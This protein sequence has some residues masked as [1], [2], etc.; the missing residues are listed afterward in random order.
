MITVDSRK[1]PVSLVPAANK[2]VVSTF[3]ET[4]IAVHERKS[5]A[6]PVTLLGQR[7][8]RYLQVTEKIYNELLRHDQER[9]VFRWT[10]D[11][12]FPGDMLTGINQGAS[13]CLYMGHG[14]PTGWSG[15]YGV[16]SHHIAAFKYK[17]AAAIISLCCWTAGRKD[18][19]FSFCES[20]IMQGI[21]AFAIGAVKP[22]LF[23]ENTRWA[24]NFSTAM[25]RGVETA[26]AL[27][28]A[29]CPSQRSADHYRLFG[30][31]TVPLLADEGF[32][33]AA[34]KIKIYA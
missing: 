31:P 23:T 18:V 27:V 4:A 34:D 16:R 17:P 2:A 30:D 3:V 19:K 8:P 24:I 15:Y 12:V 6:Q 20:L 5:P 7:Q 13:V 9:K 14:R 26:A 29:S 1:V 32:I 25:Q 33:S 10:S 21:T 22:T 11:A 28:R